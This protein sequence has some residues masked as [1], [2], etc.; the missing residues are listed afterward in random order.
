VGLPD[1]GGSGG[2]VYD[3]AAKVPGDQPPTLEQ[4]RRM[5]Q[6]L[7]ADRFQLKFH[8]DKKELP[9]YALVVAKNGSKLVSTPGRPCDR[10]PGR[11]ADDPNLPFLTSWER[12]PE[13]LGMFADRPV[14]DKTGY[15]GHYCTLDGQEPMFS[16]NMPG[17]AAGRGRG[18]AGGRPP[19]ESDLGVTIF[20]EVQPK[21]GLRLEA[22][23]EPVD[24]LVIDHVS[25][26]SAN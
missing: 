16:L 15:E 10:L 21:W 24:V 2:D 5:L 22:Q 6:T 7:L 25:R 26:P 17:L 4:A 3:V 8:R 1:W 14:F 20:S 12:I 19:P 11:A 13:M 18:A 9:A 23:K